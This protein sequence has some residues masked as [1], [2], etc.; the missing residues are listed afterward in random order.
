MGM[1][2]GAVALVLA[3]G[4]MP[5]QASSTPLVT[6]VVQVDPGDIVACQVTNAGKRD[7]QVAVE[8]VS[9]AGATVFS[10]G[11]TLPAGHGDAVPSG[12]A[13]NTLAFCRFTVVA[14][15]A[16]DARASLCVVPSGSPR[17]TAVVD[18]R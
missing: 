15:V 7:M 2:V 3:L 18:A 13:T 1:R 9:A 16:R 14:G 17:C 8:L 4:G 5:A 6:T 12:T 11:L 10:Q